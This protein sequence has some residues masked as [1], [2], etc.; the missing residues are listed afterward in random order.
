MEALAFG[1]HGVYVWPCYAMA[2]LVLL[3]VSLSPLWR[4]R[5]WRRREAARARG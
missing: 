3:H 5:R 4:R 2:A 1:D